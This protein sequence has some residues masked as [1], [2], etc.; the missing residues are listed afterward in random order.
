MC[1]LSPAD[2]DLVAQAYRIWLSPEYTD[3]HRQ[4]YA[5]WEVALDTA[6]TEL[7]YPVRFGA[8]DWGEFFPLPQDEIASRSS[9]SPHFVERTHAGLENKA[10]AQRLGTAQPV[11]TRRPLASSGDS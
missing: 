6:I 10:F 4:A 3:A 9:K 7:G 8:L 2:R 11:P 5:R 1:K